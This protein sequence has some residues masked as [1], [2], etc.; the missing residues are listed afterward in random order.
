MKLTDFQ[1]KTTQGLFFGLA[2]GI[3]IG[4][5]FMISFINNYTTNVER[6]YKECA[7][8]Y[9]ELAY[10]ENLIINNN[11]LNSSKVVNYGLENIS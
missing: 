3:V 2:I 6:E 11:V 5:I 8:A 9:N 10:K 1:A 4:C 7:E